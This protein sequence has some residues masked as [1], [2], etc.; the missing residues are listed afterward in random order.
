MPLSV[1]GM[2]SCFGVVWD[3]GMESCS[4]SRIVP[5]F[6]KD[7]VTVVCIGIDWWD[8]MVSIIPCVQS[9]GKEYS[10]LATLI[11]ISYFWVNS[12]SETNTFKSLVGLE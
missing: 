1:I 2:V 11:K 7:S 4:G 9:S 6:N 5:G 10:K 12:K 3:K 8:Y